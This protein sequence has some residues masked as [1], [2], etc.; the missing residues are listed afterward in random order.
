[1]STRIAI[2]GAGPAGFFGADQL[3]KAGFAVD[4]L[5]RL[6]TPYAEDMTRVAGGVTAAT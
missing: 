1:M 2:A 4:L 5:D 3:L 6:P